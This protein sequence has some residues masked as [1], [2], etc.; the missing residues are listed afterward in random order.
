MKKSASK[1]FLSLALSAAMV[2]PVLAGCQPKQTST[3]SGG[4][5]AQSSSEPTEIHMMNRVNAQVDFTNNSVFQEIEKQAN[6]KLVI[7]APPINNYTDRLQIVMASGDIPDIVYNWGGGDANYQKWASDGLLADITDK[8][9][10]YPNLMSNLS[11]DMWDAVK[12][13]DGKIYSVPK[14]NIDGY[15][16]YLVNQQWLK[17]VGLQTP[18]TL[19]EFE[20][21]C[22]AFTTKD[23]DGNG[24]NDTYGVSSV[25]YNI[26]F[27]QSAFDLSDGVKDVDGQYK[28]MEKREGYFPYLTYMRK[29]FSEGVLDPEFFTNKTYAD[30]DK[31]LQSKVGF[32]SSH[33]VGVLGMVA[34]QPGAEDIY[35]YHVPIQDANGKANCYVSLPMWGTWMIGKGTRNLDGVL[36]FLDWGNSQEGFTLMSIGVKGVDYNSYNPDTK[37]IDRTAEQAQALI[38]K[39]SS[40]TTVSFALKGQS[41]VIENGDTPARLKVYNDQYDA[42]KK[43][44]TEFRLP[45]VT[46]VNCPKYVN[47]S[48]TN[49]DD[50]KARDNNVIQYITGETT[51]EQLKSYFETQYYPAIAD[52]EKEYVAYLNTLNK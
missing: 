18:T 49:P 51:L 12:T 41:A 19:D 32:L 35:S 44:V 34:L 29:L 24:Q 4:S 26:P 52:A 10:N 17:K 30:R 22:K 14:A 37:E 50:V 46:A 48:T 40:Y 20:N 9:N 47:F 5:E 42:M 33:Q 45:S 15:W 11:K 43:A 25:G 1:K 16:G 13:A 21:V 28:I 31:L 36:K 23:P 8:I 2:I 6:V 7:D 38:T 3:G 27:I 39:A